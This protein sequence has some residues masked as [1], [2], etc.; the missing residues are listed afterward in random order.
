[1]RDTARELKVALRS[2]G[3]ARLFTATVVLVLGLGIGA[4]TAIFNVAYPLLVRPL[5]YPHARTLVWV[6]NRYLPGGQTGAVSAPEFW[7]YRRNEPALSSLSGI[8]PTSANLTGTAT[9]LRLE[10][11]RVSPGYFELL[12]VS[13]LL[14]RTFTTEEESPHRAPVIIIS[15]G[16]WRDAFGADPGVI[17]RS[18]SLDNRAYT[19]VGVM[20]PGYP[21]LGPRLF[22]T[23]RADYWEPLVLDPAT[24]DRQAVE[25][26]SIFVVG[27][28]VPGADTAAAS[29]GLTAALGRVE[30]TH[31]TGSST[32]QRDVLAVPLSR[33]VASD[34]TPLVGPLMIATGFLLL[35]TCVN[36]TSLLVARS[37]ARSAEAALRAALGASRAGLFRLALD[38]AVLLGLGG[39][40]VGLGLAFLLHGAL[41]SLLPPSLPAADAFSDG[42]PVLAFDLALSLVA[43]LAAGL[44]PGF[45]LARGGLHAGLAAAGGRG[46]ARASRRRVWRSLVAFQV[47]GAVALATGAGLLLRTMTQLRAVDLGFD[48]THLLM[49]QVNASRTT[50]NTSERVRNLYQTIDARIK[51]LPDVSAVAASWQIPLQSGVSDWPLMAEAG[52]SRDW[53][54]ADPN[55]VSLDYFRTMGIGLVAGRF[56]E[57]ADLTRVNGAV[58]LNETA[59]RRLWPD[60]VAVGRRINVSF[61][62]PVW[63]EVVGV[64]ADVRGRGVVLEPRPQWYVTFGDSPF[65]GISVLTLSVRTTVSPEQLRAR[66]APILAGVDPDV[67]IGRVTSMAQQIAGTLSD[68]RLLASTLTALGAMALLLSSIGVYGLVAFTLQTRR[69]EI[70]VRMALGASRGAVLRLVAGQTARLGAL[71]VATGVLGALAAGRLLARFLYGVSPTDALTL[72]AVVAIVCLTIGAASILPARRAASLDPSR[73]LAED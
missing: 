20:P 30:T 10:G 61:G 58:I 26:H 62:T 70:G 22:P 33:R 60:G 44:I 43:G 9:P 14:G 72:G 53:L 45:R 25:R 38:E 29:R 69:R 19:V 34:A 17:G 12:G 1:M 57:P 48:T 4:N 35:L 55:L 7:E 73:A 18:V 41:A 66:L 24:F 27:R 6:M 56:F 15:H 64:V 37:Q 32:R 3:Q 40:V 28:L 13:P 59:A 21:A 31:A 5:P 46:S 54:S 68:Q 42:F 50:Y 47:A 49:V 23:R 71:G 65:K 11:W 16:L 36:V 67:P 39:G 52:R 8:S 2:L 63:R 51:A